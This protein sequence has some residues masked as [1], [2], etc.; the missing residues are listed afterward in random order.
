MCLTHTKESHWNRYR[1]WKP[2]GLLTV[3]ALTP[4][5]WEV[6]VFDENVRVPDYAALPLPGPGRR[7]GI[8][9]AGQPRVRNRGRLSQ[10]PSAGGHGRH[11]RDDVPR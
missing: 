5:E 9:L 10:P 2:L 3:A 4:P 1:V 7:R 6:T 11:T 8:H